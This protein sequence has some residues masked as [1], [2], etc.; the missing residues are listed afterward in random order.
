MSVGGDKEVRLAVC[1]NRDSSDALRA[2][3][4]SII[5]PDAPRRVRS[6]YVVLKHTSEWQIADIQKDPEGTE[7]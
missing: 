7:C 4:T 2:D 3:G 5:P 1:T 6:V